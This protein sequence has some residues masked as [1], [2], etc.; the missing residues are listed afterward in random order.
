MAQL[1][2]YARGLAFHDHYAFVGL[3]KIREKKEFGGLSIEQREKELQCG[4]WV[5]DL[6]TGQ[7]IGFMAFETG[8]EEIFAVDVLPGMKYPSII[9]VK[10]DVIN[11][12]FVVPSGPEKKP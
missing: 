4:V 12:I 1:P 10:K 11:G 8:C 5:I 7:T 9:G 3:S 2:G 6:D